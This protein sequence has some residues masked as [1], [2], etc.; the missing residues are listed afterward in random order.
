MAA[1][2]ATAHWETMMKQFLTLAAAAALAAVAAI[3]PAR[4]AEVASAK[5]AKAGGSVSA[6]LA[7][8]AGSA[9]VIVMFGNAVP[10]V[11]MSRGARAA[12]TA[13][14]SIVAARQS[15]IIADI[16]G[17]SSSRGVAAPKGLK[18]FEFTPG[19]AVSAT[20]R[21]LAALDRPALS[22]SLPRIQMPQAWA[23]GATGAATGGNR[24][25]AVI[26]TGVRRSHEFFRQAGRMLSGRNACYNTI[27]ASFS[28]VARCKAAG[29]TTT[30]AKLENVA[31]AGDDCTLNAAAN[32]NNLIFGC[33]H[34]T[35]VAGIAA[36]FNVQPGVGEPLYGAARNGRIVAVNV[37]SR[38][39]NKTI[40]GGDAF[41]RRDGCLMSYSSDQVKGM[42]H[43]YKHRAELKLAAV[44][45]ALG[46]STR[47]NTTA[48]DDDPRVAV[49][50][51]L[52]TAGIP[53][54]ISAGN[55]GHR[56]GV[57]RPGC[58][59]SAI[60]VASGVKTG[61][62]A[63]QAT[64]NWGAGVDMI[65]PGVG[66]IGPFSTNDSAYTTASGTSIAVPH[67]AG[68]ITALRSIRPNATIAAIEQALEDRGAPL[69]LGGITRSEIRVQRAISAIP[70]Q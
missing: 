45:L 23:A 49:I 16:W 17:T 26:D 43:V 18:R 3:V 42:E 50:N 19:F 33:G 29:A 63:L 60:T 66:I 65:A 35:T 68:A 13:A 22:T 55:N 59:S 37:F 25:V 31:S 2:R 14:A 44:T 39:T 69:A 57:A 7:G 52:R 5:L 24:S 27:D 53:T 46:S 41:W 20:A 10:R 48:C 34:G 61:A 1:P 58:I 28:S 32:S 15:A 67:V 9:R 64:S 30:V 56:N 4:S 47:P 12:D 62:V 8:K 70:L 38:V 51:K 11:D 54:V 6:V 40:C 36:G 21:D